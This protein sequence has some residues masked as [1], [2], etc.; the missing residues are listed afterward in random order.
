MGT[1]L[2]AMSRSSR[3]TGIRQSRSESS[4][5]SRIAVTA[6][7]FEPASSCSTSEGSTIECTI[8][9]KLLVVDNAVA[10]VGGRNVGNQ[11]FQMDPES[12]FA[13]DD[14][15]AAGAQTGQASPQFHEYLQQ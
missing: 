7:R 13:D 5:R 1:P 8:N 3:W 15:F 11:Y 2:P 14:V 10:L 9:C 4:I 6:A 12:Q